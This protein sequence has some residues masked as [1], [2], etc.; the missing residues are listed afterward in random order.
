MAQEK[1]FAIFLLK[2]VGMSEI[3]KRK[4]EL[5]IVAGELRVRSSQ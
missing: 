5:F 1:S 2:A 4:K 3:K